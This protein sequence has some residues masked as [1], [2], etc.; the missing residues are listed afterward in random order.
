MSIAY[1]Q[2]PLSRLINNLQNLCSTKEH[3]ILLALGMKYENKVYIWPFRRIFGFALTYT[4]HAFNHHDMLHLL[5]L[6]QKTDTTHK[7][8][9]RKSK[10]MWYSKWAST[11]LVFSNVSNFCVKFAVSIFKNILSAAKLSVILCLLQKT[12][13]GP[14]RYPFNWSIITILLL[15]FKY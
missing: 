2:L 1:S 12:V 8:L 10:R 14:L 7:S 11:E 5:T 6:Q 15:K 3:N 9:L 4:C 13:S